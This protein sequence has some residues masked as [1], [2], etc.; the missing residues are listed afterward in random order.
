MDGVRGYIYVAVVHT[1]GADLYSGGSALN[2]PK[3]L[4]FEPLKEVRET[5]KFINTDVV[6]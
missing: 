4:S 6:V 5:L 3:E 2:P 1:G